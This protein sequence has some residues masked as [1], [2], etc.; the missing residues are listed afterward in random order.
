MWDN[1]LEESCLKDRG[2]KIAF[3]QMEKEMRDYT[4]AQKSFNYSN[5][6]FTFFLLGPGIYV[7]M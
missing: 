7:W 6:F 2:G 1:N 5:I 3:C 4:K